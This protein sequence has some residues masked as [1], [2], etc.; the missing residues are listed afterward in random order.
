MTPGACQAFCPALQVLFLL[1][2]SFPLDI[3]NRKNEYDN[4]FT[5]INS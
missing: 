1:D 2:I 5:S 4:V 3:Y